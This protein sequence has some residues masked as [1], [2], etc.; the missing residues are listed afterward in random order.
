MLFALIHVTPAA[1]QATS[2]A[3]TGVGEGGPDPNKAHIRLGPVWMDP[4]I[5]L[6]NLGIDSNVFY[7]PPDKNPKEDFTATVTPAVDMW[8]GIGRTWLTGGLKEDIVWYQKYA[9]ERSLSNTYKVGW[10]VPLNRFDIDTGAQLAQVTDRPGYEID[11]RAKRDEVTYRGLFEVRALSKTLFGVR[12]EHLS[13]NYDPSDQYLGVNLQQSL[14]QVSTTYGFQ[15][16]EEL[17]PLTSVSFAVTRIQDR[18]EFSPERNADS[19]AYTGTISF[20]PYAVIKG[21]ATIG[22]RDYQPISAV[23]PGYQGATAHADLTYTLA[24]ATRFTFAAIRDVQYSYDVTQP[25][26]L[27]TG[28]D[29]SL[30]QQVFGPVDVLVRGALHHLAYRDTI[31]VAVA[32][33][34]RVDDVKSYGGGFGYHLGDNLRLGFNLDKVTRDSPLPDHRYD[35]LKFGTSVTY[36]F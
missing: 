2:G 34:D 16:R 31:G 1:A 33:V 21:S 35:D 15:I 10:R 9:T 32:A 18:F 30:A 3:T 14:N 23:V 26:Y 8:L 7:D 27:E 12:A 11:T 5:A 29:G 20:D 17:T 13:V 4:T 28:L 19:T 22:Y 25:Y 6:T 36:N 24:G